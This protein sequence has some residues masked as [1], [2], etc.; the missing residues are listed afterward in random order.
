M[1]INAILPGILA[2]LGVGLVFWHFAGRRRADPGDA[3]SQHAEAAFE[4]ASRL[5][6]APR[7]PLRARLSG[8]L[9]QGARPLLR[10]QRGSK[11]QAKLTGAGLSLKPHEFVVVQLACV[12]LL[13]GAGWLRFGSALVAAVAG[14]AGY[15]LPSIWVRRQDKKRRRKIDS[16]L[17]DM[18]T[19]L[20][21]GLR[22]GFSIQQSVASV[23]ESNKQPISGEMNRAVRETMLGIELE[24]A[25]LHLNERLQSKDFDMMM[26]AISIHRRVGGNL[27]EVMDKISGVIRERVRIAGEVRVLTAQARA[28]GYIVTGLPFAVGGMLSVISPGYEGPLFKSPVGWGLIAVGL[29]SIGVGF[30]I[31]RKITDIQP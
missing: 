17:A 24:V 13:A 6:P 15:F 31:I 22:A 11:L 8:V 3:V 16:Q 19:Q 27:A 18:I 12:A 2:A 23:A 14:L 29:V 7:E 28:S 9:S 5:P 30:A 20:A 21:N 26:T 25:L 4:A 10:G 1:T